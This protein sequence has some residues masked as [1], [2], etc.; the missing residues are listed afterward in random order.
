[1]PGFHFGTDPGRPP[2]PAQKNPRRR[3]FVGGVPNGPLGF[4]A[5]CRRDARTAA[6]NGNGLY[7]V[8]DEHAELLVVA[9]QRAADPPPV[10]H[11]CTA[12]FARRICEVADA[13]RIALDVAK[14]GGLPDAQH[15]L[16]P[17]LVAISRNGRPAVL[18]RLA[19]LIFYQYLRAVA[20]A[21]SVGEGDATGVDD[22]AVLTAVGTSFTDNTL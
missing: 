17:P 13:L 3:Q 1:M 9:H 20:V 6:D 5:C 8:F 15:G 12:Q 4:A 22:D 2:H 21:C 11:P 7:I 19:S 16:P 14:L 10:F 18:Y